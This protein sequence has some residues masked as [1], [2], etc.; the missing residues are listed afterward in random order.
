MIPLDHVFEADEGRSYI[1]FMDKKHLPFVLKAGDGTPATEYF[2]M[3]TQEFVNQ[4]FQEA[5][6]SVLPERVI[7]AAK[8]LAETVSVHLKQPAPP[9]KVR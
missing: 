8:S 7:D 4:F 5:E 3:R 1:A 9:I 2:G 6:A